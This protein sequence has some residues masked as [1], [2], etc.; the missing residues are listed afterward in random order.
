MT[1]NYNS[2]YNP[3]DVIPQA[4][5]T[6]TLETI[7]GL[8][9]GHIDAPESA[10]PYCTPVGT[11]AVGALLNKI[12][13]T[14]FIPYV[15]NYQQIQPWNVLPNSS[16]DDEAKK[17]IN[18]DLN[19]ASVLIALS[20]LKDYLPYLRCL[21]LFLRQMLYQHTTAYNSLLDIKDFMSKYSDIKKAILNQTAEKLDD[22]AFYT[23]IRK[24][25]GLPD[26][27]VMAANAE[28]TVA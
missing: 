19:G 6:S 17:K 10:A 2:F 25:Y 24:Y 12:D 13:T 1:G 21:L 20:S 23:A 16:F 8:Y 5:Q 11:L 26:L 3:L 14:A 15:I 4:W 27:R 28:T 7:P 18:K 9:N 22:D